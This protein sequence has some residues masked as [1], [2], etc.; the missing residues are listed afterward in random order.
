MIVTYTQT[1]LSCLAFQSNERPGSRLQGEQR[2]LRASYTETEPVDSCCKASE[3][4]GNL[5]VCLLWQ[6]WPNTIPHLFHL[7]YQLQNTQ[8]TCFTKGIPG[9]VSIDTFNEHSIKVLIDT[10]STS[11]L[12]LGWNLINSLLI[13]GRVST[14][15]Y[16]YKLY[17]ST[18]DG[19]C[20]TGWLLTDCQVRCP[21]CV[22]R[23]SMETLDCRCL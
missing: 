4:H 11:R 13:I 3:F 19:V 20:K 22:D 7:Y 21:L 8:I 12:I 23:V 14:D 15:S 17:Q 9:Q 2:E 1:I 6:L 18:L 16:V 5:Q 10:R